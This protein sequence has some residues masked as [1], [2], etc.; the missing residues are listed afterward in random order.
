MP[1]CP[2]RIADLRWHPITSLPGPRPLPIRAPS[3][4][5]P[6]S[7][8]GTARSR[9]FPARRRPDRP[10]LG[11]I[12][13]IATPIRPRS[14]PFLALGFRAPHPETAAPRRTGIVS[15]ALRH[16]GTGPG[17][18]LRAI[19]RC[20]GTV[21]RPALVVWGNAGARPFPSMVRCHPHSRGI[22][23]VSPAFPARGAV[24]VSVAFPRSRHLSESAAT[25]AIVGLTQ[26]TYRSA[27]AAIVEF[28]TDMVGSEEF[29]RAH[30]CG[31]SRVHRRHRLLPPSTRRGHAH[32]GPGCLQ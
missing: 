10:P 23:A 18:G 7:W 5:P 3:T 6:L 16:T 21:R 25:V 17:V 4:A 8:P 2:R 24:G 20:R 12:G 32:D 13:S 31:P 11:R 9:R 28:D 30:C 19:H 1:R 15:V 26:M 29:L 14:W 27:L 22:P